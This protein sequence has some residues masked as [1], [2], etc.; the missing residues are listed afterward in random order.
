MP[1]EAVDDN[2]QDT[3]SIEPTSGTGV[4]IGAAHSLRVHEALS[5]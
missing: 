5:Y 4:L 2:E 3:L 1:L